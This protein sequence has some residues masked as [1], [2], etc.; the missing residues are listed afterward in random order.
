VNIGKENFT[1]TLWYSVEK[2]IF[3]TKKKLPN[4]VYTA[5]EPA[6]DPN[7]WLLPAPSLHHARTRAHT[8]KLWKWFHQHQC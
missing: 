4:F 2:L 3:F 1:Q 7:C 8:H 5:V 6:D